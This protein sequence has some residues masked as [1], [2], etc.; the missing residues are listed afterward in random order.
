MS[1]QGQALRSS[2]RAPVPASSFV[3]V[4][5]GPTT[6]TATSSW[7]FDTSRPMNTR[8]HPWW[9]LPDEKL[10][11]RPGLAD[12]SSVSLVAVR[13]FTTRGRAAPFQPAIS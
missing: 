9:A 7:S 5:A 11:A 13:A 6:P 1:S 3:T 2:S 8:S 4:Q 12:S 10:V